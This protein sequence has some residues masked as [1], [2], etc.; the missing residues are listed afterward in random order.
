MR[1]LSRL[2]SRPAATAVV[3]DSVVPTTAT[4]RLVKDNM[5]ISRKCQSVPWG[6]LG[7]TLSHQWPVRQRNACPDVYKRH[8]R[9]QKRH[10][11]VQ[12]RHSRV[13]K[14]QPHVYKRHRRVPISNPSYPPLCPPRHP[15]PSRPSY[16]Y[17]TNPGHWHP[18]RRQTL[19]QNRYTL[20]DSLSGPYADHIQ[21]LSSLPS[22]S[23]EMALSSRTTSLCTYCPCPSCSKRGTLCQ[24]TCSSCKKRGVKCKGLPKSV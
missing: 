7:Q 20:P 8:S 21:E 11:R 10:S 17:P 22:E 13:Q 15:H 4:K 18:S 1:L 3:G 6:V 2:P 19:S 5:S 14:R 12:K 24:H 9:V 23:E 16:L